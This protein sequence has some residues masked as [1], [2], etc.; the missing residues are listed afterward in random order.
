[1]FFHLCKALFSSSLQFKGKFVDGQITSKYR[2]RA[3]LKTFSST[4]TSLLLVSTKNHDLCEI[5]VL[6]GFITT[7]DW[8]QNQ[9]DLSG[10]TLSMRRVTGM[11][12][13]WIVDFRC[14]TWPE[15]QRS[16]FLVLT[17]KSAVSGDKNALTTVRDK[18]PAYIALS[19]LQSLTF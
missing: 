14:W 4:E 17:K 12:S 5:P 10:L 7:I 19:W 8:D 6:N 1:M 2:D 9:S 18:P 3:P 15:S 13:Q 11:G 16:W